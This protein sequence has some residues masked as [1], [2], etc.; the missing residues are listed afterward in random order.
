MHIIQHMTIRKRSS[1]QELPLGID[2]LLKNKS[3]SFYN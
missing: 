3:K 1:I 2:G